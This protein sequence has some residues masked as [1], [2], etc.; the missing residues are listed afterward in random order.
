[1]AY[2]MFVLANGQPLGSFVH[3]AKLTKVFLSFDVLHQFITGSPH[4]H[5]MTVSRSTGGGRL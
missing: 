2:G 1:M 5:W 4:A 3:T